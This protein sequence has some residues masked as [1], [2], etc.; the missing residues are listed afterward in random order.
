MNSWTAGGGGRGG[1][2]AGEGQVE[3]RERQKGRWK[4][5]DMLGWGRKEGTVSSRDRQGYGGMFAQAVWRQQ[6]GR[7]ACAWWRACNVAELSGNNHPDG[8]AEC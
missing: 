5:R 6:E 4:S 1:G 2:M 8:K 3:R 7:Q